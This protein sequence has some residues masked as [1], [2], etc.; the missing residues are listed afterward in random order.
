MITSMATRGSDPPASIITVLVVEDDAAMRDEFAAMVRATPGLLLWGVADSLAA[1]RALLAAQRAP[2]VALIDLGLPDGD[3]TE[4]IRELAANGGGAS[5]LVAT[6]FGDETRVIRAIEAGARGYLLKDSSLDEFS[7]A[8]RLVH[9]GGAP[10]SPRVASHL[11]KRFAAPAPAPRK[12]P[13][14]GAGV[15]ERLSAREAEI[16]SLIAQGHSVAEVAQ[17]VHLSPHTITT[18][19]KHIYDKLA[20]NNRVQAVNRAR[21]TGQIK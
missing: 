20:V 18:H 13:P 21:A 10:L 16:L 17:L 3:G 6:V 7:R 15:P 19:I 8:I 9:D 1:A 11:L 2:N 4:L 14:A 12:P 5:P